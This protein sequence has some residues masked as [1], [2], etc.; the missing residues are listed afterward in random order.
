MLSRLIIIIMFHKRLSYIFFKYNTMH[1]LEVNPICISNLEIQIG[2]NGG[3]FNW[4][5][6][7]MPFG[8]YMVGI[9]SVKIKDIEPLLLK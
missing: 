9:K 8:D 1:F 5:P 6:I 2:F 7:Y 3:Y 4:H